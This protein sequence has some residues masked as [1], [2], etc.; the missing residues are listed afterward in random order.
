M[1]KATSTITITTE[2]AKCFVVPNSMIT[3]NDLY[4]PETRI[5]W[6][7]ELARIN[8]V[9]VADM[10]NEP[11]VELWFTDKESLGS[12]NLCD[13]GFTAEVN[14]EECFFVPSITYLPVSFFKDLKEGDKIHFTVPI[15]NP[16]VGIKASLVMTVELNQRD[17]R[18]RRFGDFQDVLGSLLG[19]MKVSA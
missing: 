18:Y 1:I 12:E 9:K 16:A 13:H 6:L 5:P 8:N 10:A 4:N 2:T 11:L 14:G 15:E 7:E 3:A 19:K 17:F